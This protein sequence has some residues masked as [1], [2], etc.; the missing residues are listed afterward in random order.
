MNKSGE[1][2]RERRRVVFG[3]LWEMKEDRDGLERE[4]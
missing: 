3:S 1:K 2:R 4:R